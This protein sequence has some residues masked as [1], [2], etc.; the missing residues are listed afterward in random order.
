MCKPFANSEAWLH[1]CIA[2]QHT[3]ALDEGNDC[4]AVETPWQDG[5][6]AL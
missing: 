6:D 2:V 1:L 3:Q 4:E 5:H